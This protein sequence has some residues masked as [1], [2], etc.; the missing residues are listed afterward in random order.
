MN[1]KHA[2]SLVIGLI[3]LITGGCAY[4]NTFYNAEKYFAE[5]QAQP[6][7][8]NGRPAPNAIRDYNKAMKKCGII[9]TD[10]K[11]S[12]YADDALML[13]A[14]CLYYKGSQ[15]SQALEKLDDLITLYPTSEFVPEAML[16]KAMTKHAFNRK[17][18]AYQMLRD[19]IADATYTDD[20]PRALSLLANYFL[21]EEDFVQ[22]AYYFEK[23]INE[24]PESDEYEQAYFLR[25]QALHISGLYEESNAVFYELLTSKVSKKL[26]WMPAIIL[27]T[28]TWS[29]VN[30]PPQLSTPKDC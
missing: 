24:Y 17:E 21:Q 18:E 15:Y 19:F 28:I 4:Y 6:L 11:D 12:Q 13:L 3:L 16:Y 14:K 9:L 10:Y 2:V 22:A 26:N 20:H 29:S 1:R 27:R 8:D 30:L 23:I 25:G 7:R 5:A